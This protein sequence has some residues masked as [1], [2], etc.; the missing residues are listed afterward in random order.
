LQQGTALGPI[1]ELVL[2]DNAAPALPLPEDKRLKLVTGDI[3]DRDTV[4]RLIMPGT[5]AVFSPRRDRQRRSRG[6]PRSR[7]PGQSSTAPAPSSMPAAPLGPRRGSF[8]PVR[9]VLWRRPSAAVGDE[10]AL[11]PQTSYGTQKAL[12]ESWSTTTAAGLCRRPARCAC[13]PWCRRG[14]QTR[15]LDLCLFDHPRAALRQDACAVAPTR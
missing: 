10:T 13:R 8:S 9:P 11:T 5:D 4:T 6:E 3:A 14:A 7:L 12:G 15:R 2:F 1:D